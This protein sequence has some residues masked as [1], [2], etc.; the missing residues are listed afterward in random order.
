MWY[1]LKVNDKNISQEEKDLW[2]DDCVEKS[3]KKR[4]C[5]NSEF[6]KDMSKKFDMHENSVHVK[7]VWLIVFY[8]TIISPGWL[9]KN[10]WLQ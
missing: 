6:M 8:E 7:D 2:S 1:I 3:C 4:E 5:F 9:Y 10:I